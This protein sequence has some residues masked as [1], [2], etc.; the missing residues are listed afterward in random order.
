MTAT[1][2]RSKKANDEEQQ[3]QAMKDLPEK[4]DGPAPDF[5]QDEPIPYT[6]TDTGGVDPAQPGEDVDKALEKTDTDADVENLLEEH[7]KAKAFDEIDALNSEVSQAFD[8]WFSANE[9][10]KAK[11]KT[12]EAA[13]IELREFI[14]R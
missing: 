7:R 3:A 11:K 9:H 12:Y 5:D 13:V 4:E 14:H 1:K 6:T 10:A 2:K 8:R